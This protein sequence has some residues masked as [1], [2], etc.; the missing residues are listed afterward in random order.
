MKLPVERPDKIEKVLVL[1][2]AT[3]SELKIPAPIYAYVTNS[4]RVG[5]LPLEHAYLAR[6]ESHGVL[7]LG[8]I[9]PTTRVFSPYSQ[10]LTP[11]RRSSNDVVNGLLV[12]V[13]EMTRLEKLE[14]IL[15]IPGISVVREL[16][17]VD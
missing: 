9:D 10:I 16:V 17:P 7:K 11:Y 13:E 2:G 6:Y 14:N 12:T 5:G 1:Q 3:C 15:A 8:M 4:G